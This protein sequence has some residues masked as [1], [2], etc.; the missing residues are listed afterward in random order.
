MYFRKKSPGDFQFARENLP[1]VVKISKPTIQDALKSIVT[2]FESGKVPDAISYSVFPMADIPSANWSFLNRVIMYIS[3]TSDA[4]G[5]YQWKK[6][7][8]C[9]NKG[10]KAFYILVPRFKK[11]ESEKPEPDEEEMPEVTVTLAPL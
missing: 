1:E 8:R 2:C 3:G 4:R 6:A 7:K 11:I 10:A 5:F 9:V